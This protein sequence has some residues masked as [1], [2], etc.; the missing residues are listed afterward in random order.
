[1]E[2]GEE[3]GVTPG[4]DRGQSGEGDAE[5]EREVERPR[6]YQVGERR[7]WV[8]LAFLGEQL[9]RRH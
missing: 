7:D 8:R 3:G 9:F 5:V 1:M 6:R 4:R 2:V